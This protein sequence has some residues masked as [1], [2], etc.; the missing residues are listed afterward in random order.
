MYTIDGPI[1]LKFGNAVEELEDTLNRKRCGGSQKN[2]TQ[3][4]KQNDDD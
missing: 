1:I 3:N 4:Q 2:K